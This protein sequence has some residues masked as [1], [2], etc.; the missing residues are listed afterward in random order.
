MRDMPVDIDDPRVFAQQIDPTHAP[1]IALAD[2]TLTAQ[3]IAS[4][5][6]AHRA[7]TRLVVEHLRLD[8]A[9]LLAEAIVAA[10]S[11]NA[12]R[13]LWRAVVAAWSPSWRE[14]SGF[15]M[16]LFAL[17]VVVVS[18][19]EPGDPDRT[20][21]PL[22]G[23]LPHAE[24]LA[25]ILREHRALNGNETIA[26]APALLASDAIDVSRL[27]ALMALQTVGLGVQKYDF[28]PASIEVWR[29]HQDVHLRFLMGTAIAAPHI[30]LL[31]ADDVA[32]WGLPLARELA[33]QLSAPGV[34]VL[35]LP[36]APLSPPAALQQGRA[37]QRDVGAQL[38]ASNAIR[39]LRAS[40]GE[41]VGVISAHRCASAPGGGELRLSLSNPLDP[42]QAEGFRCPLF[43]TDRAGD[44]AT[45]LLDLLRDCRVADVRIFPGVHPDR[46]PKTGMILVFK[47]AG[48]G[49][50][51]TLH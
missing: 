4:A 42:R 19:V 5:D 36:R 43:C 46:D 45:M 34:S 18:G 27:G 48:E 13:A 10:P 44:V 12:A 17:P 9:P 8:R 15:A 3:S 39:R 16:T 22:P 28:P 25:A 26:L 2:A 38:F 20:Q 31:A 7:L 47:P 32:K 24:R 41:P 33:S 29:E 11:P 40:V 21:P 37:V 14:E 6:E 30:D 23:V 1:L 51:P 35:A 50:E 49:I